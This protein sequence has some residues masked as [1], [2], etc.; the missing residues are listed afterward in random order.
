MPLL[1]KEL[2]K[3]ENRF[4]DFAELAVSAPLE[5]A[6]SEM[7]NLFNLLT[8]DEVA[9]YIYSEWMDKAFYNPFSP[10]RNASIYSKAVERM[11]SDGILSMDDCAP[12]LRHRDWIN[13]NLTGQKAVVPGVSLSGERTLILVL[14]LGC[15]SCREA[16]DRLSSNPEW[17]GFRKIA[18]GMGIGPEPATEGWEYYHPDNAQAVFDIS[19]SPVYFTVSQSGEV[20]IPYTPAI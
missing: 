18:I 8:Q 4:A 15:P 17:D 19:V 20:D 10:C 13:Y 5:V 12:Y 1:E 9:Y 11:V 7:D 14:D 3:S 16:I 2:P 6:L